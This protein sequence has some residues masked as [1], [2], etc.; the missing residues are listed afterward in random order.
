M[1]KE[2]QTAIKSELMIDSDVIKYFVPV[3]LYDYTTLSQIEEELNQYGCGITLKFLDL[4]SE[5]LQTKSK[6]IFIC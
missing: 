5:F 4:D 6:N 1:L 3:L 2:I